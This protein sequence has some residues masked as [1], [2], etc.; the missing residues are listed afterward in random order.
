MMTGTTP[1][2]IL[3]PKKELG[4]DGLPRKICGKLDLSQPLTGD[5]PSKIVI[6]T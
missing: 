1:A 6:V 5:K 3:Y 2:T 4:P